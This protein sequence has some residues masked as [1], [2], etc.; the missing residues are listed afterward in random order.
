MVIP[1]KLNENRVRGMS[2]G[3]GIPHTRPP[4]K[5]GCRYRPGFDLIFHSNFT[6]YFTVGRKHPPH[7][8]LGRCN[9]PNLNG[10]GG[11]GRTLAASRPRDF[12]SRAS[13]SSATPAQIP[14]TVHFTYTHGNGKNQA[15]PGKSAL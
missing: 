4:A 2:V 3:G 8:Y 10:A 5:C 1:S 6:F 15:S 9:Y 11:G 14:D 7:R 12:E 13:A